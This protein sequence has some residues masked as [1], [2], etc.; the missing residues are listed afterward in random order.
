MPISPPVNRIERQE[1]SFT[2]TWPA[3]WISAVLD[4]RPLIWWWPEWLEITWLGGWSILS[5]SLV[6]RRGQ[7]YYIWLG[8]TGVLV[9]TVSGLCYLALLQG[10]WLP[11]VPSV[12]AIVIT[13]CGVILYQKH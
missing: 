13:T 12:V 2:P 3:S 10:G 11:L 7:R 5:G 6:W 8:L 4:Q 9:A 1:L